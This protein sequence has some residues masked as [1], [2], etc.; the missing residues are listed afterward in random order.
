MIYADLTGGQHGTKIYE[1]KVTQ[2]AVET[3][4]KWANELPEKRRTNMLLMTKFELFIYC[5]LH[6]VFKS[7][8]VL[9]RRQYGKA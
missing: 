3:C 6:A 9:A 1:K 8:K 2:V 4:G 5:S 7:H